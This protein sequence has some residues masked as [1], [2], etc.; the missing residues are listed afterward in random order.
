MFSIRQPMRRFVAY[1]LLMLAT[2][3]GGGYRLSAQALPEL[4]LEADFTT[5]FDNTEYASMKGVSSGTLFGARLTP[6]VGLEWHERNELM[7][8][9]DLYQDFGHNKFLSKAKLQLYYAYRSP[10]VK[11]YAGI[12]PRSAM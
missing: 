3:V 11:L 5:L 6:K 4:R 2:L 10:E 8:G 1:I 9:A 12:F 7:V